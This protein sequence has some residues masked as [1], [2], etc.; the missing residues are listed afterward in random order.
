MLYPLKFKPIYKTKIWGNSRIKKHLN[1]TDAP[2]KCGESWEISTLQGDESIITNGFLAGNKLN[3]ILEVYMDDLVGK[4]TFEKFGLEFPLLVKFLDAHEQLSIQV[5][6]NDEIAKRRHHAYGKTEMWYV[7][8]ADPDAEIIMGFNEKVSKEQFFEALENREFLNMLNIEKKL[9]HGDAFFIPAGRIHSIGK[10]V[11]VAEIQQVSD[12]TYRLYDWDR[13]GLDGKPRELHT[14]WA[15]DAIDYKHYSNY[16]T[17]YKKATNT[18]NSIVNSQYFSVNYLN[19]TQPLIRDFNEYDTFVI[20]MAIDKPFTIKYEDGETTV[21]KG[22]T[23]LVPASIPYYQIIP[24]NDKTEI[25][26]IFINNK[27]NDTNEN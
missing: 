3:E 1:R 20:Y 13:V 2:E 19:I 18:P 8:E 5:H 11:L 16:K 21:I 27:K 12:I 10:G 25:L 9:K 14:E 26:E 17:Q 22:E 4:T 15:I 23:L 24:Q 7:I 6:P